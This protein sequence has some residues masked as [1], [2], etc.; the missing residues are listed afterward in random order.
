MLLPGLSALA[1]PRG[2]ASIYACLCDMAFEWFPE[3][4]YDSSRSTLPCDCWDI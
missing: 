1:Y 4:G 3:Y 2:L